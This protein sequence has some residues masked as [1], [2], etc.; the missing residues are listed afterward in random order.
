[1][2]ATTV[3]VGV[4]KKLELGSIVALLVV[5]MAL[6][7]H[8]PMPLLTGPVSAMQ[9][10]GEIAVALLLFA[11]G[12]DL[13]PTQVWSIRR[14]VF[15]LGA[16]QY[17]LTTLAILAFLAVT[18][19]IAHVKWQSVLVV[20]LGLAMSSAAIP[21]P[22]LQERGETATIQGRA[23]LAIDIFQGFMIVP[24]LALIPILA[25]G[26]T[27]GGDF[28]DLK[29]TLE[30]VGALAGVFV[31]GRYVLPRLLTLT[32]RDLGPS[33]FAVMV[34]AAVF[35]AGW[36]MEAVGISM[37][38]G[39][40]MIGV[41]LSTTVYAEQVKAAVT[42]AKQVLLAIFFIA[43]GMAIDARQL[44]DFKGDLL[45]YVPALL[46]IKFVVVFFLA[47]AFGL[48]LRST[49]LTA[50]LM[51]P[52]DEIAYVMLASANANGLL[53]AREYAVALSVISLSFVVS[54]VLINFGYKLSERL[55]HARPTDAP[56]EPFAAAEGSVVVAE[57]GYAGRT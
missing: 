37:A 17:V 48:A 3:A 42:P 36:W 2:G 13:Q 43:I 28:L 14:L 52:F 27:H 50:L 12:L 34:L 31:L 56:Q 45:L 25:V 10:I 44:L 24:I 4:A 30:V 7:P 26:S 46:L 6:G 47:H 55:N 15:G 29:K 18:I 20:G 57:Y 21:F 22:I 40:F 33:G 38:L 53:G 39:A 1:M 41:L 5:G 19:G 32:A 49:I 16:A 8:S 9:A 23:V 11:V 54:P 51:M 35:F